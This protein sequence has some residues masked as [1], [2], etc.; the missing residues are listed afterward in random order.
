MAVRSTETAAVVGGVRMF[1]EWLSRVELYHAFVV[2]DFQ[3]A[4]YVPGPD[5]ASFPS[6]LRDYVTWDAVH[7][8][9]LVI[10]A[11]QWSGNTVA[12]THSPY[13]V[14]LA[15]LA[16]LAELT[17]SRASAAVLP[18]T[19][20]ESTADT[21]DFDQRRAAR[22]VLQGGVLSYSVEGTG[23]LWQP[24]APS[25]VV[26]RRVGK[27]AARAIDAIAAGD[28]ERA[29]APPRSGTY[30]KTVSLRKSRLP[31]R[32]GIKRAGPLRAP[33]VHVLDPAQALVSL[34]AA[35]LGGFRQAVVCHDTLYGGDRIGIAVP[36]DAK[37]ALNE[38]MRDMDSTI[39]PNFASV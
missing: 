8:E 13:K 28:G 38:L 31:R 23:L 9:L 3:H 6:F 4:T 11:L 39:A 5:N 15:T 22:E 33:D 14:F 24:A 7:I 1:K 2:G 27:L 17:V 35:K 16:L 26:L 37:E 19:L 29:F 34:V 18:V 10:A 20:I 36:P 25:R 30:N 21:D 12:D 32:A